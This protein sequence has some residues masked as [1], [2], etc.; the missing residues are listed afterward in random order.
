M[1]KRVCVHVFVATGGFFR[2]DSGSCSNFATIC[3]V[4]DSTERRSVGESEARRP[5]ARASSAARISSARRCS[6][7]IAGAA[8]SSRCRCTKRAAS[9]ATIAS[10]RGSSRIRRSRLD[11]A[12]D[13]KSSTLRTVQPG[14]SA[15]AGSTS[16]GTARSTSSSGRRRTPISR[17]VITCSGDEVAEKTTSTSRSASASPSASITSASS[18]SASS[19]SARGGAAGNGQAADSAVSQVQPDE[20]PHRARA[21][22]ERAAG[23]EVAELALRELDGDRRDGDGMTGDLGLGAHAAAGLDRL[24]EEPVQHRAAR[25]LFQRE[26]VRGAHLAQDLRLARDERVEAGRDAKE[27]AGRL[28]VL[29]AEERVAGAEQAQ[30]RLRAPA[31]RGGVEAGD[32]ELGAVARRERDG[33]VAVRGEA[34]HD[35]GRARLAHAQL[36]AP[37]D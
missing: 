13:S 17:A 16:R 11:A 34:P 18:R 14:S 5:A 21:D 23:G 20:L 33:L 35:L 1:E 29:V 37:L 3:D 12:T 28:L 31:R 27:V 22:D 4:R 24:L 30:L 9:S 15:T 25:A 2:A 8:E 26:P 36:L 10:A 6:D 32:V 19:A 7:A